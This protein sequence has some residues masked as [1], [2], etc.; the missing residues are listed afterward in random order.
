MP[1]AFPVH[2]YVPLYYI[3]P[4]FHS[5]FGRHLYTKYLLE[6]LGVSVHLSGI[7]MS[8]STPIASQAITVIPVVPHHCELLFYWTGYLWMSAMLLL[9]WLLCVLVH[10]LF[11][12]QLPW[13]SSSM[14][15][16]VTSGQHDVFLLPPMTPGHSRVVVGPA[17][18]PQQQPVS[19]ASS[20]LCQ[21]CHGSSASRFLFQSWVSHHL[22]IYMFGVCTG[23]C[24]LLSGAML[25]AIPTYGGTTI[26]VCTIVTPWSLPTAGICAIWQWSLGHTRYAQWLLPPLLWVG[27]AFCYPAT[28]SAILQPFPLYGGAYSFGGLVESHPIPPPSLHGG[29]GVLF[30]RFGSNW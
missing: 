10:Y 21:L 1:H 26:G 27:G 13:L 9:W 25:D 6:S 23:V 24:F 20:G 14:G 19:D 5:D 2:L 28:Q 16:P 3:F 8:V 22:F 7:S 11:S 12:P 4:K 17:S 30:S 15:L 29:E 18:L